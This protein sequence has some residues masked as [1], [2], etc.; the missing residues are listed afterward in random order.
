MKIATF[1]IN[2]INRR[3]PNLLAWLRAAK[4]DAVALQELKADDGDFPAAAI[5]A[6]GYGAVWRGQ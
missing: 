1:N 3:L 6:A 4:P 5:E 2:N